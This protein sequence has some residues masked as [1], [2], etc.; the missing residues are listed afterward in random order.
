MTLATVR[1]NLTGG[2]VKASPVGTN[3]LDATVKIPAETAAGARYEMFRVPSRARIHGTS[4]IYW[5]D[6]DNT[7]DLMIDIGIANIDGNVTDDPDAINN[8][9]DTSS[10]GNALV[11]PDHANFGKMVW[12]LAGLSSDPGGEVYITVT[13]TDHESETEGDVSMTLVYSVD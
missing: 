6:L 4:R 13:T 2:N 8:G 12:E 10:A 7:T 11:I 5:D 3:T 1:T 9:L